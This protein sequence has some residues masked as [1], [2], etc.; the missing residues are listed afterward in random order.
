MPP[1]MRRVR[2][3][4]VIRWVIRWVLRE[5]STGLYLASDIAKAD[6]WTPRI[7]EARFFSTP[8]GA[9]HEWAVMDLDWPVVY[10]GSLVPLADEQFFTR[11]VARWKT[12][13]FR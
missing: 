13:V 11:I 5:E 1:A 8:D 4:D 9:F 10:D 7:R 2:R 3:E 12:V 6:R